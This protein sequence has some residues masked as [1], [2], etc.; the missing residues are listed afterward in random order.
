MSRAGSE[1]GDATL[2]GGIVRSVAAN[3]SVVSSSLRGDAVLTL[4]ATAALGVVLVFTF[5]GLGTPPEAAAARRAD[6][7]QVEWTVREVRRRADGSLVWNH[8][9]RGTPVRDADAVFVGPDSEAVLTLVDGARL[10][11]EANSLVVVRLPRARSRGDQPAVELVRGSASG[12]AA[13]DALALRAGAAAITVRRG[14]QSRVVVRGDGATQ[15]DVGSGSAEVQTGRGA[16]AL[17]PGERQEV[18]AAGDLR[19]PARRLE[20]T[21]VAPTNGARIYSTD[22]RPDVRF[23]W[24]PLEGT[25]P[26]W[27]DL[28]RDPSFHA[29]LRTVEVTA[30]D[31]TLE[32]LAAGVYHWRIRRLGSGGEIASQEWRLTVIDERPPVLYEPRAGDILQPAG[33]VIAFAWTSVRNESA[34]TLEIARDEQWG[35]A[36]RRVT[37]DRPYHVQREQLPEGRHC[38]RVQVQ[39][40]A[41]PATPWSAARCFEVLH[42]PRLGAPEV[43]DPQLDRGRR[44]EGT[45]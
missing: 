30:T 16:S 42:K 21:L 12:T 3:V 6:I 4:L 22:R 35:A 10:E 19:G 7:G 15:V 45:P 11:I 26:Y 32:A 34:Y 25:G 27:L 14:S 31:V 13:G 29:V 44:G 9:R 5:S 2:G 38:A 24:R 28:S 37:A 20:P 40:P 33:A 36:A 18:G 41:R 43:F 23:A 39:D 1:E 17:Q 8:A